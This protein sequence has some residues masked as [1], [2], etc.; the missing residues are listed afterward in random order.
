MIHITR[1]TTSL[2][3]FSEEEVREGLRTGR[4]TSSDL[5]WREAFNA[6]AEAV[7]KLDSHGLPVEAFLGA[8]GVPGMTAW[9]ASLV[10]AAKA[11]T[12]ASTSRRL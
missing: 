8:A 2:G 7:R 3:T 12:K 1:G 11:P 10:A 4:F 6:P 9:A 5:G